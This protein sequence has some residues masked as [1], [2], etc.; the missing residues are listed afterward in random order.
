MNA[1]SY[2]NNSSF[3]LRPSAPYL[4]R[5]RVQKSVDRTEWNVRK[6]M[7]TRKRIQSHS[8][9]TMVE[10]LVAGLVLVTSVV[11]LIQFMYVNFGLTGRAQDLTAGYSMA[12]T[13]IELVREQGFTNAA[14]GTT[15][16]YYDG[17]ATY[18]PSTSQT[19]SSVFSCSAAITSDAF[20]GA[21]PAP[22][23]LR[24]VTVSVTRLSTNA[25]VYSTTTALANY[26]F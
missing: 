6:N 14:E 13:A 19:T 3:T 22:T 4:W 7:S 26:G 21:N 23:A 15:T 24:T 11:A 16:V 18:P 8:G 10:V 5:F 12:R 20:S 2:K 9:L 1:D 17:N 25:P